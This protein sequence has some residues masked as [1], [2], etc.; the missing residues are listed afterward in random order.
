MRCVAM[1]LFGLFSVIPALAQTPALKTV[2]AASLRQG[3]LAREMAA[4]S[5]GLGLATGTASY[6]GQEPGIELLGTTVKLVDSEGKEGYATILAVSPAQ[7]NWIVPEWPADGKAKVFVASGSGVVSEGEITV[8]EVA[9]GLYSADGAGKG[10]AAAGA[11][12]VSADGTRTSLQT[13]LCAVEGGVC[14]PLPLD[15]AVPGELVVG[16]YA[17]GVRR[18][19]QVAVRLG[20]E[21]VPVRSA[22]QRPGTPGIDEIVIL[23]PSALAGRGDLETVV[24]ADGLESNPVVLAIGTPPHAVRELRPG[25]IRAG[26]LSA[27]IEAL[28][29][30]LGDVSAIR[31]HPPDG[32]A[33][34]GV[35]ASANSVRARVSILATATPGTRLVTLESERGRSNPVPVT[36]QT[37]APRIT[38]MSPYNAVQG[39][40]AAQFKIEGDNLTGVS[41]VE[42]SPAS[43]I[44]VTNLRASAAEVTAA[45]TIAADATPGA[46]AV[47]VTGPGGISNLLTFTILRRPLIASLNPNKAEAAQSV[48][49]MIAGSDLAGVTAV[50]FSPPAGITVSGVRASA[51]QVTATIA[52]AAG[53]AAGERQVSVTGAQGPSNPLAFT[54]APSG[55]YDGEWVGGTSQGVTVGFTVK[56][57]VIT[58]LTYGFWAAG[59]PGQ[60]CLVV[61]F[62]ITR[63]S[64][65]ILGN[66]FS[67]GEF[68]G[69]FTSPRE[70]NGKIAATPVY[71]PTRPSSCS[72]SLVEATWT[73][74]R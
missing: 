6:A 44:T 58:Q 68:S 19:A 42:F 64:L 34:S 21:M 55:V 51:T 45:L 62:S 3:P 5:L 10:Y 1:C 13:L 11:V 60:N 22:G 27:E 54:V 50:Q 57:N 47:S 30:G 53:A 49:L 20:G 2:S 26:Q 8:S 24:V 23:V 39:A 69:T 29:E 28:G 9:P 74:I 40:T 46:R 56:G 63:P 41:R 12:R 66:T 48:S 61:N 35:Q 43:G 25:A 38:T 37:S 71:S 14:L 31:F 59:V 18:A 36:L 32:V 33:V 67:N 15:P 17:T 73:A 4:F 16:L 52:I 70:A 65:P 72:E 7:V